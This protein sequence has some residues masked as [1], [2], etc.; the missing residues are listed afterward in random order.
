MDSLSIPTELELPY[1]KQLARRAA[2]V[3]KELHVHVHIHHHMHIIHWHACLWIPTVH[4]HSFACFFAYLAQSVSPLVVF[5]VSFRLEPIIIVF[6]NNSCS[7]L[8]HF[9]AI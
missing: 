7:F 8:L 2:I 6:A 9:E 1:P 4:F 3:S 5:F